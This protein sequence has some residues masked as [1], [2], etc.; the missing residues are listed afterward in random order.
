[1]ENA[2]TAFPQ[3]KSYPDDYVILESE[4]ASELQYEVDDFIRNMAEVPSTP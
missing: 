1:M 4:H 3:L 2:K